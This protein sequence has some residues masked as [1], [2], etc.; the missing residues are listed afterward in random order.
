M[1]VII[2]V[3]TIG[4]IIQLTHLSSI[5]FHLNLFVLY[6]F[7]EQLKFTYRRRETVNRYQRS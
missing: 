5:E 3:V 6:D 7:Y 1:M 2:I 4:D